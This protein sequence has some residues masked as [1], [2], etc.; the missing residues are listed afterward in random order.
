M[1]KRQL[2][3]VV[4]GFRQHGVRPEHRSLVESTP[5]RLLAARDLLADGGL[6]TLVT[7]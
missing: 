5:E 2:R 4:I 6:R 3:V 1:Y 7:V